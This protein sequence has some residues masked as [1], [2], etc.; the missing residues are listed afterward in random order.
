MGGSDHLG[1]LKGRI[2]G[3]GSISHL[4]G[5]GAGGPDVERQEGLSDYPLPSLQMDL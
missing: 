5:E 3:T 4:G 2:K 1:V